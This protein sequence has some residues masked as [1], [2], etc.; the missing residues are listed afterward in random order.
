MQKPTPSNITTTVMKKMYVVLYNVMEFSLIKWLPIVICILIFIK[1]DVSDVIAVFGG[2]LSAISTFFVA[3]CASCFDNI[4]STAKETVMGLSDIIAT[5][6][7]VVAGILASSI[8][9]ITNASLICH[10]TIECIIYAGSIVETGYT[11]IATNIAELIPNIGVCVYNAITNVIGI[12][13][14]LCNIFMIIG[15]T[16][17]EVF[18]HSSDC[19]MRIL[20][21]IPDVVSNVN[22]GIIQFGTTLC[23]IANAAVNSGKLGVTAFHATFHAVKRAFSNLSEHR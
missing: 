17:Q 13:T 23:V 16:T 1:F 7:A 6:V 15:V 3:S 22:S 18:S 12:T 2:T 8:A 20:Y 11:S 10:E 9:V 4:T 14:Y 5:V 21:Y 19:L